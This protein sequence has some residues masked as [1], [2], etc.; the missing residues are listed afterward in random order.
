M[1]TWASSGLP[2]RRPL[3]VARLPCLVSGHFLFEGR[4]TIP[5]ARFPRLINSAFFLGS[6]SVLAQPRKS[7]A[8]R[9]CS[10]SMAGP[11]CRR[12]GLV[13]DLHHRPRRGLLAAVHLV[14]P[15]EVPVLRCAVEFPVPVSLDVPVIGVGFPPALDRRRFWFNCRGSS[16]SNV[17]CSDLQRN[18]KV[19]ETDTPQCQCR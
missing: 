12:R 19:G 11:R 4:P 16:A 1:A 17:G 9:K 5:S 14:Q 3:R 15:I 13:V 10:G 18:T 7:A 2:P 6:V 8:A